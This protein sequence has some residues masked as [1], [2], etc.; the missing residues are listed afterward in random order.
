[1]QAHLTIGPRM[2]TW[3]PDHVQVHPSRIYFSS[4]PG[5]A[6]PHRSKSWN[7]LLL[8]NNVLSLCWTRPHLSSQSQLDTWLWW[9]YAQ[10]FWGSCF[11]FIQDAI[12]TFYEQQLL[13]SLSS[14][15]TNPQP[16]H[17]GQLGTVGSDNS[18]YH[19]KSKLTN[20]IYIYWAQIQCCCCRKC[21][22]GA[23]SLGFYSHSTS[24]R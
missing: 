6:L 9:C 24:M 10:G 3:L 12:C 23:N 11:I 8:L 15:P 16:A 13:Y 20:G 5:I 1:M 2:E 18:D 19:Y 17:P 14:L 7:L 21:F 22:T 4:I